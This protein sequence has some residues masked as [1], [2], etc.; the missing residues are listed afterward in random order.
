MDKTFI[1][2]WGEGYS[3]MSDDGEANV[4]SN[5]GLDEF[6]EEQGYSPK[7]IKH[8]SELDVGQSYNVD[9]VIECHSVVRIKQKGNDMKSQG[10]VLLDTKEVIE[11]MPRQQAIGFVRDIIEQLNDKHGDSF[12]ERDG[13]EFAT[14][15]FP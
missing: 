6:T 4:D 2:V 8:I 3:T 15:Y 12:D 10:Q 7:D 13:F 9:C 11:N 1:G 5:M 14:L